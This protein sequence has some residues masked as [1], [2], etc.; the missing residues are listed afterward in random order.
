MI[1]AESYFSHNKIHQIGLWALKA[2]L[3]TKIFS[4]IVLMEL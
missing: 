2:I 4:N 1:F 3:K